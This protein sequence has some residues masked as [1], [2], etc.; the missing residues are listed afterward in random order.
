L[1]N[2]L[3][4]EIRALPLAKSA[5]YATSLYF[6]EAIGVDLQCLLRARLDADRT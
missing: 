3:D 5:F 1:A 4:G 6:A 2:D